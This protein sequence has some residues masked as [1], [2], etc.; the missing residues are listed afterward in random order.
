MGLQAPW[1]I[2]I[3]RG[4]EHTGDQKR[5]SLPGK[6]RLFLAPAVPFGSLDPW[7]TAGGY[8]A[9]SQGAKVLT[10]DFPGERVPLMDCGRAGA[11][12]SHLRA[13]RAQME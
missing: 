1:T 13:A 7:H 12:L 6:S 9:P 2:V 4:W 5:A 10:S 11:C 3:T 8:W